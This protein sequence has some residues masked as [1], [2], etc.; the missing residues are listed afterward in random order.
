MLNMKIDIS[1]V[2][3]ISFFQSQAMPC[4]GANTTLFLKKAFLDIGNAAR[5]AQFRIC[6][7]HAGWSLGNQPWL[8]PLGKC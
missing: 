3:R 1:W 8:S 2:V 4:V 6:T 7:F 5:T